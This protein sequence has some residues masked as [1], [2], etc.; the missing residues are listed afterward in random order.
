MVVLYEVEG[1]VGGLC[2][3]D[4][5]YSVVLCGVQCR[6]EVCL[7]LGEVIVGSLVVV[8]A[9]A[10]G[11]RGVYVGFFP[12]AVSLWICLARSCSCLCF[13]G[14]GEVAGGEVGSNLEVEA[15]ARYSSGSL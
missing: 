12:C 8:F 2:M 7:D 9:G 1:D 15:R 10:T 4:A 3:V 14:R 6:L 11:T 13:E 5:E